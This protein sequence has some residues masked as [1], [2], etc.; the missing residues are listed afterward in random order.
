MSSLQGEQSR[1]IAIYSERPYE[2]EANL[3]YQSAEEVM[4]LDILVEGQLESMVSAYITHK[5]FLF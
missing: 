4:V 3:S 5:Q 2:L 1:S